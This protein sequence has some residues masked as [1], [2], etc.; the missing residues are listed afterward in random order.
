[1]CR[2]RR[3][4]G[5]GGDGATKQHPEGD[6]KDRYEQGIPVRFLH[7]AGIIESQNHR[8]LWVGRDL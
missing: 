5:Q 1:M 3:E 7:C 6:S 8:R 2:H 4:E